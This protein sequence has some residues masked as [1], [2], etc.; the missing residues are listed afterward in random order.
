MRLLL[1]YFSGTGNTDYVARYLAHKIGAGPFEIDLRS[2]EW[3][4]AEVLTGFDLLVLGFP[5]YAADSP[6]FVQAY[7]RRLP[8]GE[9]RGA[10]VFCTKGA[11][12]GR[13]VQR[14]LQRLAD[15]GYVPLGGGS[16]IMPGSDGLSM[17]GKDSWLARKALEKDYDRLED[18]DRLADVLAATLRDLHNGRPVEALRESLPRRPVGALS[19]GVWAAVYRAS[20]GYCRDRLH[21]D[22]RCEGCNLCLRV[23]PVDN[24]DMQDSRPHFAD[25]CILCLRCLHACPQEAIQIARF[26][27]DKFRWRGPK[28]DFK[29]LRMRPDHP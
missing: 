6:E 19:D 16:V 17:V 4:P 15:R 28:G 24:I 26:T 11:Y 13:A 25:S 1:I 29:P 14:N 5:V 22:Q 7:L 9:G 27:T 12:A 10:F 20:E 23:C 3:Q 8:P 18:A 21:A 2:I